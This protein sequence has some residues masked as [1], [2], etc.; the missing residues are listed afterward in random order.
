MHEKA[1]MIIYIHTHNNSSF[2]FYIYCSIIYTLFCSLLSSSHVLE[3]LQSVAERALAFFLNI[4]CVPLFGCTI[5]NLTSLLLIGICLWNIAVAYNAAMSNLHMV[6]GS[7]VAKSMGDY[8][9][10][11]CFIFTS[12]VYQIFHVRKVPLPSYSLVSSGLK[13]ENDISASE[14]LW[15]WHELIFIKGLNS[16]WHIVRTQ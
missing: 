5:L 6:R 1:H 10:Q 12:S 7:V 8:G 9:D 13:T 4:A 14:L 11:Q 3:I 16:D 2:Y 15:N